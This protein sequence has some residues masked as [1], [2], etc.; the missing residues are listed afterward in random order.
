M[1]LTEEE[2]D[3]K[4]LLAKL[5]MDSEEFHPEA[6]NNVL[7]KLWEYEQENFPIDEPEH[8]EFARMLVEEYFDIIK[9]C[10]P[11]SSMGGARKA[12]IACATKDV[13]NGINESMVNDP[14]FRQN[15]ARMEDL[16]LEIGKLNK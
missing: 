14:Y 11:R 13:E 15:M 1:I 6:L 12:A 3:A 16:K 8:D 9:T 5:M 7:D 4:L 10:L 2:Y